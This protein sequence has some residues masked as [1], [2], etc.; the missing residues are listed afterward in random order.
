MRPVGSALFI[1]LCSTKEAPTCQKAFQ[2]ICRVKDS[3]KSVF[4]WIRQHRHAILAATGLTL[5][6]TAIAAGE[7]LSFLPLA[8][9][10]IGL[11]SLGMIR[12][13]LAKKALKEGNERV[14]ALQKN[15]NEFKAKLPRA[16]RNPQSIEEIDAFVNEIAAESTHF[17]KVLKDNNAA[18]AKRF[19]QCLAPYVITQENY[20]N[21]LRALQD[22]PERQWTH[23]AYRNFAQLFLTQIQHEAQSSID[24]EEAWVKALRKRAD[25]A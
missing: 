23:H 9:L 3:T 8:I 12:Q 17:Q 24:R 20:K 2:T 16:N 19:Q 7:S 1:P 6:L 11:G 13:H 18:D 15:L 25:R 22:N 5:C 10:M 4:E 21:R 14:A